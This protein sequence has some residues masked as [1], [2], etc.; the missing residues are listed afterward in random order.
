MVGLKNRR[1]ATMILVGVSLLALVGF[2]ALAAIARP[3][4]VTGNMSP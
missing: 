4:V 2:M 1:G 3:Q